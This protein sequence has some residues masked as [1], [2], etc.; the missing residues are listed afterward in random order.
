[1]KIAYSHLVQHIEESP[2]IE[3][4]SDSLF[5][6]GHEHEI[7]GGIFDLEFTPN[8]GDCLSVDGLL[9]DL[10]AFY[11]IN[12]GQEIFS[13]KLDELLIDFENL[14]ESICPQISFLKLEIDEVPEIYKDSLGDY[15]LDLSLNKNNFF[16][17]VSNYLSYETGQ[18]THCYDVIQ[19]TVS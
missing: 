11:T 19:L 13:E 16:T 18:P 10:A 8:R 15:F 14:S 3:Q 7:D 9:R 6:L 5:Q 4:I 1:M 2:N 17:D 12:P